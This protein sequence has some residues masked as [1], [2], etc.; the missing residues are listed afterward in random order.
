MRKLV[1]AASI[2]LLACL[3]VAAA[4][5]P[6]AASPLD[7]MADLR[8]AEADAGKTPEG[9]P[10][11]SALSMLATQ[12]SFVGDT[13]RAIGTFE[14]AHFREGADMLSDGE[15]KQFIADHEVRDALQAILE[16]T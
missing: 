5:G 7:Y 4:D 8:K 10:F 6:Q 16:Q 3:P 1:H 12:Q 13:E 9:S 14:R 15:A 2:A 11:N